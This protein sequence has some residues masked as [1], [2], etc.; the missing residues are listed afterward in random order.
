ME[1][2]EGREGRGSERGKREEKRERVEDRNRGHN[3]RVGRNVHAETRETSTSTL[4]NSS[5]ISFDDALPFTVTAR[6]T[7]KFCKLFMY[8]FQC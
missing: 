7:Y 8:P 4:A 6:A 2:R 5:E 3:K 1:I